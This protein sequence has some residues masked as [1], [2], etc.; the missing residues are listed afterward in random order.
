[1]KL[2]TVN[3]KNTSTF[4]SLL[5]L[6]FFF[7]GTSSSKA[8]SISFLDE[9]KLN[10]GKEYSCDPIFLP[11]NI[12]TLKQKVESTK[13]DSKNGQILKNIAPRS[14]WKSSFGF[15]PIWFG[16]K[17]YLFESPLISGGQIMVQW[18][19]IE[20]K[21]GVYDFSKIEKMLKAYYDRKLYT[22]IQINGNEKP[23]YL[24]DEIPW[25][26]NVKWSLQVQDKK[27]TLMYWYPQYAENY[28][29]LI[30][31]FAQFL[32]SSSY[33]KSVL[34]IRFNLNA[35][36]TEHLEVPTKVN[37]KVGVVNP[38]LCSAYF[39]PKNADPHFTTEWSKAEKIK[40]EN[41]VLKSYMESV[42]PVAHLFLRNN[43]DENLISMAQ[44]ELQ[45]GKIGFFHTSSEP[46]PRSKDGELK[47]LTF[48][49]YSRS[50]QT[51]SYAEEWADCWGV[52]G[53][54]E[55]S[56]FCSPEQWNYWRLL[57]DLHVG[58]SH[59]GM[60]GSIWAYAYGE[61]APENK[62]FED[63]TPSTRREE[64][65]RGIEFAYKYIGQHNNP[66]KS[67]GAFIA[68]RQ[69]TE[70]L[71]MAQHPEFYKNYPNFGINIFTN[72]YSF[73]STRLPDQSEGLKLVGPSD[74]RFG[75]FA[76]KMKENDQLKIAFHPLFTKALYLKPVVIRVIYFDD[77]N[78][79]WKLKYGNS[80]FNVVSTGSKRWMTKE[81]KV[82]GAERQNSLEKGA[83]IEKG[84]LATA[85]ELLTLQPDL[86][87][88][89]LKGTPI[90]HLVEMDRSTI[91]Q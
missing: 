51:T 25:I 6:L 72:D 17:D 49:K 34:G 77:Q 76:R 83:V 84:Q 27:G 35:I 90:F 82:L 89:A 12:W 24:F 63:K 1:M 8:Q 88:T 86:V 5:F 30:K 54:E 67:P 10:N 44:P 13:A 38:R 31:A 20:L 28:A 46:E 11:K 56:H 58:I 48:N 4:F 59:I 18:K 3:L 41:A 36:G 45:S 62:Q 43:I 64:I 26:E 33:L 75:A 91:I 7:I 73:L 85:D 87:I 9:D 29:N 61:E 39:Y 2:H 70:N 32:S 47:L 71:S 69:S 57:C 19:E 65:R 78:T 22:T 68:F 80:L 23:D 40:Y 15:F 74:Q 42:S 60:Y 55:D 79:E 37:S 16:A 52:H 14:E 21:K 53:S 50:K 81:F 66:A